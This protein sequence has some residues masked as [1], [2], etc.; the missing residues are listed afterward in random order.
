MFIL[1][2]LGSTTT[3]VLSPGAVEGFI[4]MSVFLKTNHQ[5]PA[6]A[7]ITIAATTSPIASFLFP[8]PAAS[9]ENV[10]G[11]AT[12]AGAATGAATGVAT[13]AAAGGFLPE[14]LRGAAVLREGGFAFVIRR[15]R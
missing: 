12:G 5:I 11:T 10:M 1:T 4:E 6:A 7:R 2:Q 14:D 8:P 15:F 3:A 9:S 13:G